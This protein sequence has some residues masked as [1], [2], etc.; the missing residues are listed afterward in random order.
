MFIRG[1]NYIFDSVHIIWCLRHSLSSTI[2]FTTQKDCRVSIY[3]SDKRNAIKHPQKS[4]DSY[5]QM[6]ARNRVAPLISESRNRQ[7]RGGRRGLDGNV[8][9]LYYAY[10]MQMYADVC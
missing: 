1:L 3:K 5:M 9:K 6:Y 4:D 7:G 2:Y 10:G 8:V